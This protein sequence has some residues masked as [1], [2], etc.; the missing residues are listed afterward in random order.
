MVWT[1]KDVVHMERIGRI[2]DSTVVLQPLEV[3]A[4]TIFFMH[5][6]LSAGLS[7]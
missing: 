3:F 7:I 2:L 4:T 5:E 1:R 6:L